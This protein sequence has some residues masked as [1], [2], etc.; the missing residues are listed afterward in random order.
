LEGIVA[1]SS[2]AA[3]EAYRRLPITALVPSPTNPR[4]T[5]N[6]ER[7]AEL[8][9]S[10]RSKGIIEPIIVRALGNGAAGKFE[11][12]CG[13]RRVRGA[14]L[15]K[16]A[17][18]PAV[19]R[20]LTDGDVLEL[21][22][23]ENVQREDVQPLEEAAG[24]AQLIKLDDKKWNADTIGARIG[25]SKAYVYQRLKLLELAAPA[26]KLMEAGKITVGHA[27]QLARLP[28]AA[29]T[30]AMKELRLG[31]DRQEISVR[32]LGNW[33]GENLFLK[34]AGAPFDLK[35]AA[36]V[37]V[38][39]PCTTCPKRSSNQGALF[40]DVDAGDVCTDSVCYRAKVD[41]TLGVI[42]AGVEVKAQKEGRPAAVRISTSSYAGDVHASVEKGVKVLVRGEGYSPAGE[43]A[44]KAT[45]YGVIWHRDRWSQG[46]PGRVGDVRRVC[47]DKSCAVHGARAGGGSRSESAAAA[48]RKLRESQ[49]RHTA[50]V[51]AAAARA[52]LEAVLAPA[53][54]LPGKV[55]HVLAAH[56]WQKAPYDDQKALIPLLGLEADK[57]QTGHRRNDGY[58]LAALAK[59][60]EGDVIRFLVM[61]AC[62]AELRF[63]PWQGGNRIPTLEAFAGAYGVK[64]APVMRKVRAG[65]PY[66]RPRRPGQVK[67]PARAGT[68]KG[69]RKL[70]GSAAVERVKAAAR[71]RLA[72]R[73]VQTSTRAA[74]AAHK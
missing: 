29:Q 42:F 38:A 55:L 49:Q 68:G 69:G 34:L 35:D 2:A 21:Q 8:A 62:V 40:S 65:L 60:R 18:V 70:A 11:I 12:V 31:G 53:T 71:R 5:F 32:H 17:E 27:V 39:G 41:A 51:H 45:T 63:S 6:K 33:I 13:E 58:V 10:I 43:K 74:A 3:G 26:A 23:I 52:A 37:K 25:K 44:C 50:K 4:K 16:L 19:I 14:G 57:W 36:L 73:N 30:R 22:A 61:A 48:A 64:I 66:V 67:P 7:L 20:T 15:A 1:E 72:R 9:E 59:R 24:Y 56:T 28:A 54:R 46:D 47:L